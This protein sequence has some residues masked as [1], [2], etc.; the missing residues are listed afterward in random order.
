MEQDWEPRERIRRWPG[1]SGADWHTLRSI[2]TV[3]LVETTNC[4]L[5]YSLSDYLF[6]DCQNRDDL[7][8]WSG[9]CS[10]KLFPFA[11]PRPCAVISSGPGR[12]FR[13]RQPGCLDV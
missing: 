4:S 10:N 1:R 8:S 3:A 2:G 13:Q 9:R 12:P 7:I 11:Y 5:R 6:K